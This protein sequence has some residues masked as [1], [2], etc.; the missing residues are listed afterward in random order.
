MVWI[1]IE[2]CVRFWTCRLDIICFYTLAWHAIIKNMIYTNI[3]VTCFVMTLS[4][5]DVCDLFIFWDRWQIEIIDDRRCA[6]VDKTRQ[7]Y[8][9][10]TFYFFLP[11]YENWFTDPGGYSSLKKMTK[12]HSYTIDRTEKQNGN[13]KQTCVNCVKKCVRVLTN[14]KFTVCVQVTLLLFVCLSAC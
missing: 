11:V 14:W 4:L 2:K 1:G 5:H 9:I 8:E 10:H 7:R 3:C 13:E 6:F 12:L